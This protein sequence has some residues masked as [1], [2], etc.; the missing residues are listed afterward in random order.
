MIDLT[1]IFQAVI[2]LLAAIVTYKVI[3]W[4]RA[5]TTNEQQAAIRATIKV[6]VFAAEQMYGAGHGK[7]KLEWVKRQLELAGFSINIAEIEAAV[8]E[9]INFPPTCVYT[10]PIDMSDDN[11]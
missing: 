6:L 8:G 7:V 11:E 10:T 5:K 3:P 9:Y 2:A 4:I 1:P